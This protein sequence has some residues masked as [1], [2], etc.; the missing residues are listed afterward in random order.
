MVLT[1]GDEGSVGLEGIIPCS[2]LVGGSCE[3]MFCW[4]G[5][6]S[7]STMGSMG[8][9]WKRSAVVSSGLFLYGKIVP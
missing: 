6:E 3:V 2:W 5:V 9:L 7:S 4:M 1:G 8:V